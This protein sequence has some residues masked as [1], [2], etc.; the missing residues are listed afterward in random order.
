MDSFLLACR[1]CGNRQFHTFHCEYGSYD[2]R[3]SLVTD[4]HR[5]GVFS[6]VDSARK[7]KASKTTIVASELLQ[8]SAALIKQRGVER[9]AEGGER[10]MKRTVESFNAMTGHK[11][12]EEDGWLFMMMLKLSRSRAGKTQPDDYKDLISYSALL[13]ECAL[14]GKV[15][16]PR[17]PS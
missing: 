5:N 3:F 16:E 10:S 15:D 1:K 13:S 14:K 8:E 7:E 11:L 6:H 9:D 2:T 17:L 4:E 12:T